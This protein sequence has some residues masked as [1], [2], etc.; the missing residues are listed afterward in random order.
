MEMNVTAYDGETTTCNIQESFK[1]SPWEPASINTLCVEV[2][3]QVC[4]E[5]LPGENLH[6]IFT[7]GMLEADNQMLLQQ[8]FFPEGVQAARCQPEIPDL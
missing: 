5:I 8:G 3:P 7:T 6:T 4:Q 2:L 1:S